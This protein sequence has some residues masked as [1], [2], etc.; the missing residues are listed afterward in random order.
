LAIT[1]I[2]SNSGLELVIHSGKYPLYDVT[3][4]IVDLDELELASKSEKLIL[5]ELHNDQRVF[6]NLIPGHCK[7]S[8]RWNLGGSTQ[9]RFNIFWTARNGSYTQSLHLKKVNGQWHHATR[10]MREKVLL[11]E[12]SESYPRNSQGEIDW[13]FF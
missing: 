5:A 12:A 1:S 13:Q 11:E 4:R 7:T 9:R 6:A 8:K 10:V 2:S 3:A